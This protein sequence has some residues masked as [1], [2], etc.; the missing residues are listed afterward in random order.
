M[1]IG[2]ASRATGVPSKTLRYYEDL[3]L[4]RP[5]RTESGYRLYDPGELG[6]VRFIV[7][8]KQLGFKLNEIADVLNLRENDTEP[9]DHV[10]SLIETR[11]A[12]IEIRIRDLTDLRAEL[13]TVRDS[14][15]GASAGPCT[16]TVCHL[17]EVAPA[18]S[19]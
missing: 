11:L 15:A 1:H 5:G 14:F 8:A 3:G 10:A 4:V 18:H 7:R 2:E 9:C 6:R 19:H 12:D 17:I 13:S 16:G